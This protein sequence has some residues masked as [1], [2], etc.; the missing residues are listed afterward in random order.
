MQRCRDCDES[1]FKKNTLNSWYESFLYWVREG[2]CFLL[3]DGLDTFEKVVP[4]KRFY[5]C[6]RTFLSTDQGEAYK[7]EIR[8][9]NE[10]AVLE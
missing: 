10:T 8:F 5:P 2:E 1:W 6:L 7:E 3:D 9:S 4:A